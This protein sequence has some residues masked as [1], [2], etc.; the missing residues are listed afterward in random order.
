[1]SRAAAKARDRQRAA[2]Y[3]AEEQVGR[4]L[5]RAAEFPVAE[6]AGSRIAVPAE[7]RFG[8]LASVQRYVDR[9]LGLNWVRARWPDA[10]A[11]PV[12]VRVRRGVTKAH[13]EPSG[14]GDADGATALI[15][16]PLAG[17]GWALRELVVL[18]ELTHHLGGADLTHGAAFT[19]RMLDL[20]DGIIGPEAA[21]LLR[22]ALSDQGADVG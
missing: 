7:R 6:V 4:I 3:A 13:Y 19:G 22:V 1:M 2:V 8:D 10:A 9:V 21:L 17:D 14:T 12:R 11:R 15:A 5:G 20:V 16:L 18:H